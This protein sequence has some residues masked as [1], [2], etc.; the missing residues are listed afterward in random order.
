MIS[1]L[2]FWWLENDNDYTAEQM[3]AM[4][5]IVLYRREPPV[6]KSRDG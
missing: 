4:L 3:A 2:L 6:M 5:Y 1:R